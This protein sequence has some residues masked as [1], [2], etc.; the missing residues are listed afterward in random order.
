MVYIDVLW[1][2]QLPVAQGFQQAGLPAAVGAY[3]GI[4]PA[5]MQKLMSTEAA[6][7]EGSN[8]V[9][10]TKGGRYALEGLAY[11]HWMLISAVKLYLP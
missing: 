6:S 2:L 3:K 7:G 10:A 5:T 9:K 1:Y 8:R 4:P 11:I